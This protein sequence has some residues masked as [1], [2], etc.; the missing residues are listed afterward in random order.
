MSLSRD[1]IYSSLSALVAGNST[2]RGVAHLCA[3][4]FWKEA[5]ALLFSSKS[6][7]IVTGFFIP[8][9]M[10]SE[11]DGPPGSVALAMCLQ[12]LGVSVEVGTD[13]N[14]MAALCAVAESV[15]FP[16]SQVIDLEKRQWQ[17][18][19]P[20][21]LVFVER[22]GRA[23]DGRYYNMRGVDITD[24]TAPL[25]SLAMTATV[26]VLAIG[27]G[28]NEVGMGN[29]KDKLRNN[30]S[31]DGDIQSI[32]RADVVLPVDVSNWGAYALAALLSLHS[33]FWVGHT[34]KEEKKMLLALQRQG[35]VDGVT[36]QHS[37]SV[38]GLGEL[39]Q[40]SIIS[41]LES[42]VQSELK[43]SALNSSE[44]DRY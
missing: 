18:I 4:S 39:E 10:A 15:G 22:L 8:S 30:L 32:V 1:S 42:L 29:L 5:M 43:A 41:G 37:L 31:T 36:H 2:G 26:P 23:T 3:P 33:N 13:T 38:D 9:V 19:V 24:F 25:D 27:D 17:S 11:T 28:G 12:R 6:V 35:A 40:Y 20:D 7:A 44:S 16:L 34:S 14:N 21:L